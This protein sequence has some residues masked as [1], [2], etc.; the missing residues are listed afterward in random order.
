MENA[1]RVFESA[2]DEFNAHDEFCF[3]S[4]T[5]INFVLCHSFSVLGMMSCLYTTIRNTYS[6]AYVIE[7]MHYMT[8]PPL[9]GDDRTRTIL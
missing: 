5:M 6:L 7:G 8:E 4:L 2:I 1:F 9:Y 3:Q